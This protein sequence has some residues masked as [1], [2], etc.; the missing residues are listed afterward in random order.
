M[1]TEGTEL[2][3]Q[4]RQHKLRRRRRAGHRQQQLRRR[5]SEVGY[6]LPCRGDQI[7]DESDPV[8]ISLVKAVPKTPARIPSGK[9][10]EQGRLSKAR[11]GYNECY[12]FSTIGGKGVKEAMARE[13]RRPKRRRF[14]LRQDDRGQP[15]VAHVN[16]TVTVL[17]VARGGRCFKVRIS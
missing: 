11:L 3:Q 16:Q 5:R 4:A 17:D 9:V 14:D 15:F 8:S 13:R 12:S 10:G 7:V 1:V 2:R 6:K